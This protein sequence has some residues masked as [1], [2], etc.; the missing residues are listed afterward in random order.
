M[1]KKTTGIS[2]AAVSYAE[3]LLDLASVD[4]KE[5]EFASELEEV[6]KLTISEPLFVALLRDPAIATEERWNT[7]KTIFQ[8]RV[9][10]LFL[11]FL[12]VLNEK[13]RFAIFGEICAGYRVLLD[14]KQNRVRV[15]VTTARLLDE[16]QLGE[17]RDR[18]STAL[19]KNATIE[20]KVDDSIIGGLVLRVE[21]RLMDGSV[22]AQLQAM[23]R[24]LI[25][26]RASA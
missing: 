19:G 7:I 20:Q 25:A 3:A 23:R 15:E 8:G 5:N 4:G 22:K 14:K 10:P 13:S 16:Q 9:S 21:D 26:S 2:P 24:Q 11:N 1:G 18:I 17:V 6:Q 12:G